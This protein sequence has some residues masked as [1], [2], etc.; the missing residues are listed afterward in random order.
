MERRTEPF[1]DV[2]AVFRADR[3]VEKIAPMQK[4]LQIQNE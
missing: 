3:H 2:R 4:H 1:V